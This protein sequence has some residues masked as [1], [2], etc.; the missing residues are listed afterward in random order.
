MSELVLHLPDEIVTR[1]QSVAEREQ[2][3]LDELV[4]EAVESYLDEQ[5]E[6]TKETLLE[7]LRQSMR[8]ALAG[9]TRP[10]DEVLAELRQKHQIN[11]DH[12]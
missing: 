7:D 9:Q 8:D 1:L 4:Q 6:P 3:S 12:G 5:E 11:A 10:A 2:V